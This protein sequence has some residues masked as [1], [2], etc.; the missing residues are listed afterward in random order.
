VL[1]AGNWKMHKGPEDAARCCRDLRDQLEWVDGVDVAVCPPFPSLSAA[2]QA[3]AGT[4][5]AV[6]AQNVHWEVEGAFTGEVSAPM[7]FELGVY[8]AIVGHS[9]RRQLFGET[10]EGIARRAAGAL[11]AGLWVIACVGETE[12]EREAGETEEVLRRQ[13]GVL[14][15]HEQLVLA[16]EPVWAIGTG[17][18]A[19][20]EQ[21]QEAHAFLR[22]LIDVPILYGGSV[23][24]DNA[25][26]LLAQPD[27]D[28]A[29]VGGASLD[30]ETF[31]A[32]CKAAAQSF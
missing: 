26:E 20:P 5:I 19:T 10:D 29:L 15:A 31:A 2:V 21:A 25:A 13:A 6:A 24:P 11:E 32:S 27:V 7:L 14:E 12:A 8:G 4:D 16:Y 17:K 22:G 28:G 30:V 3:L 23:K 18:T 1:V 9:E